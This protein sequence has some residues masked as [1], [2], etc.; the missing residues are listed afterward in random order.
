MGGEHMSATDF[1]LP[2]VELPFALPAVGPP[3]P[4]GAAGADDGGVEWAVE[5]QPP[6]PEPHDEEHEASWGV[7]L[8]SA[9]MNFHP[10]FGRTKTLIEGLAGEDL[11]TGEDLAAWEQALDIAVVIPVPE[12]EG[13]EV[14]HV[15]HLI[16]TAVDVVQTAH[17]AHHLGKVIV[18]EH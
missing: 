5:Y 18:E 16:H 10:I 2:P 11:F 4:F 7:K 14:V 1:E 3:L 15:L 6:A 9:L 12:A 8:F 13:S 17:H